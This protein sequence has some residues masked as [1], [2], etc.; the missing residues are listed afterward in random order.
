V[1]RGK[2]HERE[3][4]ILVGELSRRNRT[5]RRTNDLYHSEIDDYHPLYEVLPFEYGEQNMAYRMLM[6]H[7]KCQQNSRGF[8][9]REFF[10]E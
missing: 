9:Q 4:Q 7:I 3:T 8:D 2:P 6:D 5:E 10:C 1:E